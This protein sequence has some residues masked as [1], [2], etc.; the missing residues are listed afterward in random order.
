MLLYVSVHV[1]AAVV[2]NVV[3][4]DVAVLLVVLLVLLAARLAIQRFVCKRYPEVEGLLVEILAALDGAAA[5]ARNNEIVRLPF[6]S[7]LALEATQVLTL[8]QYVLPQ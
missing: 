2:V 8:R 1:A 5:V 3:L 4:L 6:R 7:V